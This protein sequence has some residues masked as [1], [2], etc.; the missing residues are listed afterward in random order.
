[1]SLLTPQLQAMIGRELT[2]N[3]PEELGC[4]AIRYFALAIGD[5][6]PLYV[7]DEYARSHGYPGIIAP[8]TLICETNQY[9]GLPRS[10]SGY[11]GHSWDLEVPGTRQIRGGNS[12]IFH[13][14]VRPSDVITVTWRIAGMR[15]RM[16][17]AG[18]DMLIVTSVAEFTN[19]AGDP[20]VTNTETLIFTAL[21]QS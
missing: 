16:T 15:E 11:A 10:G 3:A 21:E 7:D 2:Y 5:D 6:N 19:Q 20:L 13:Q 8:P 1:M 12:Y 17:S 9:A 4:A 18:L 14:P